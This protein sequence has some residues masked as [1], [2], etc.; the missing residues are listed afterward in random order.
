MPHLI[1]F[2]GLERSL[3][4][5]R[6]ITYGS[7]EFCASTKLT[8]DC[9]GGD[10][11]WW[12]YTGLLKSI[13]SNTVI[14][15]AIKVRMIQDF[16]ASDSQEVDLNELDKDARNEIQIG[17]F[18]GSELPLTL[19]ESCNKIVH[20]SEARLRWKNEGN[21]GSIEYWNG[22]YELWG[23]KGNKPWH[24]ELNI[25]EWCIG[26]IRFNKAIQESVDWVHVYKHDE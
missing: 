13:V 16:V 17:Q 4:I 7:P 6:H 2:D 18:I 26:M 21:E 22:V 23:N 10:Y 11:E 20:A 15:C 25:A 9:Y 12:E 24:V 8:R 3:F 1:D 19:R 5:L 14:E